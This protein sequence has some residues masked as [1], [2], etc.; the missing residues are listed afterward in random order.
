MLPLLPLL[1]DVAS[2]VM[3]NLDE[4]VYDRKL[5]WRLIDVS[6]E[7]G[8]DDCRLKLLERVPRSEKAARSLASKYDGEDGLY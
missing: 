4:S 7:R 8:E 1:L 5:E 3:L 6:Q 2:S